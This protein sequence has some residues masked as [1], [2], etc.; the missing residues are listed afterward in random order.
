VGTWGR[1]IKFY[2]VGFTLGLLLCWILFFRHNDR[3]TTGWT[4]QSRVLKFIEKSRE[5]NADSSMLCKLKCNGIT[6]DSIRK[7]CF[8]GDVDFGKSQT[9]K[10]PE[11]EYEVNL[12]INGKDVQ[13]YLGANMND[14][15]VRIIYVNPVMDG[16]KCGC[17]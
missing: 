10:E 17:N 9:K 5:I 8:T 3:D 12:K 14:S 1:R 13:F 6:L 4:P 2:L 16:A 11:H 7:A 15:T